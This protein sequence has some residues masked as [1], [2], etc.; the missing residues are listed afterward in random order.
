MRGPDQ[1][2]P[3]EAIAV[4]PTMVEQRAARPKPAPVARDENGYS[5]EPP[6]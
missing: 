2:G 6:F 4:H 5:L 1:A 3:A